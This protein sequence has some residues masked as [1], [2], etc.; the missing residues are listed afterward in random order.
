MFANLLSVGRAPDGSALVR[1]S[2]S[3]DWSKVPGL[4]V[5][6]GLIYLIWAAMQSTRYSVSLLFYLVPAAELREAL[7]S[8]PLLA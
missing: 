4:M 7:L 3:L 6:T 8:N 2:N 1:G 5:R